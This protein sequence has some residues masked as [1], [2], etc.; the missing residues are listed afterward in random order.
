MNYYIVVHVIDDDQTQFKD[1]DSS[2]DK[3]HGKSNSSQQLKHFKLN[4]IVDQEI[5]ILLCEESSNSAIVS[6]NNHT[7]LTSTSTPIQGLFYS[8][9]TQP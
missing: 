7:G 2:V 9:Y 5:Q 6:A 8:V 3:S 1:K 4:K